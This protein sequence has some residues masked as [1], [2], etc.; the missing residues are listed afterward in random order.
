MNSLHQVVRHVGIS[1][2]WQ[3]GNSQV[4]NDVRKTVRE[5]AQHGEGIVTGGALGVDSIA[6]DEMLRSNIQP[7]Q[8]VVVLPTTLATYAAHYR[9]KAG[10]GVISSEQAETLVHQL[11]EVKQR[12]TLKELGFD[13][14]NKDSYYARN[15]AVLDNSDALAAFQVNHSPGT[16]DTID[17]AKVRGMDVVHFE[18][19]IADQK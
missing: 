2:S 5:L 3:K 16:Q 1:G 8:L 9:K 18:Y 12:G 6:T 15:T 17:K 7:D 19:L 10:E 11:E 4:E 13:S 14:V